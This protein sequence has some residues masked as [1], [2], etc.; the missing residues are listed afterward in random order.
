MNNT[1]RAYLESYRALRELAASSE[2][3]EHWHTESCLK[4]FSVHGLAGHLIVRTGW[5]VLDY[6]DADLPDGA[7]PIAP[8]AYYSTV[9]AK[10]DTAEHE[11]VRVRGEEAAPN[12]PQ[13][14][15]ASYNEAAERVEERLEAEPEDRLVKVYGGLVM[16]LDDYLVT[17]ICEILVH[18][19]DLAVSLGL[20][21]PDFPGAANDL[22][23]EHLLKVARRTHGDRA[24]LMAF[25][26]RERDPA[27]S[28]RVF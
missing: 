16:R 15:L 14:L 1:R 23:L 25:S 20:D 2:L 4:D 3:T 22:A 18:A 27:Q 26:R 21:V 10:M 5:A 17:R 13:G 8:E 7:F 19:D 9:L 11:Q 12:G 6:L 24:V 28:L